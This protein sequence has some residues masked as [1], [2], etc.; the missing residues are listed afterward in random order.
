MDSSYGPFAFSSTHLA[1][2]CRNK[3]KHY[4]GIFIVNTR[5]CTEA[6]KQNTNI[7]V[8]R[9]R[10]KQLRLSMSVLILALK[11]MALKESCHSVIDFHLQTFSFK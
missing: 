2:V 10:I 7:K 3:R 8:D 5:L 6:R 1:G 4:I 11:V 9:E